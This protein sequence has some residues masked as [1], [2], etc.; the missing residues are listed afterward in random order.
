MK[1]LGAYGAAPPAPSPPSQT[2][3]AVPAAAVA[4]SR[5]AVAAPD[6]TVGAVELPQVLSP[7][8]THAEL[9]KRLPREPP[10]S[11]CDPDTLRKVAGAVAAGQSVVGRLKNH[12]AFRNPEIM[13]QLVNFVAIDEKGSNYAPQVF[14][15]SCRGMKDHVA[16]AEAQ[17]AYLEGLQAAAA[18]SATAQPLPSAVA[19]RA[20][21]VTDTSGPPGAK[22][23]K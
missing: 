7:E 11:E 14:D 22:K 18:A 17:N 23:Q 1:S 19:R 15:C 10:Q 12:T 5:P 8:A 6:P 13:G 16:L 9:E 4:A 2:P 3:A 20:M 21:E